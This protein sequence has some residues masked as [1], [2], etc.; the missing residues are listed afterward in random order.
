MKEVYEIRFHGRGG[1]GAKT[2]STILA[3]AAI[4]GGKHV[5]AFP[6]YGPERTGAPIRAY[7]RISDKPIRV[8]CNVQNPDLVAVI[9]PT[10]VEIANVTEGLNPNG[11]LIINTSRSPAELKAETKFPGKIFT[12]DATQISVDTLGMNKPNTPILGAIVKATGIV[13]LEVLKK[14]VEGTFLKKLGPEKTQK[15]LESVER[16]YNEVRMS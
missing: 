3:E 15:N 6:D 11:I 12:V 5:Q 2:A 14:E 7:T 9:D 8:H 16:A 1:Q 4:L 13:P 10:L